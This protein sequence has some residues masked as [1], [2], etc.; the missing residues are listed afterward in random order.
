MV[1]VLRPQLRSRQINALAA[2]FVALG[3]SGVGAY[4]A[5]GTSG[6]NT[7]DLTTLAT[8]IIT[9]AQAWK[10]TSSYK[11]LIKTSY[12]ALFQSISG[13]NREIHPGQYGYAASQWGLF[14]AS[15]SIAGSQYSN[16]DAI[17][18]WNA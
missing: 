9:M 7:T 18:Q 1:A 10:F 11:D 14:P 17:H 4:L 8:Q 12:Y 6:N 15:Y 5:G 2:Q 16:Y 3:W 13:I